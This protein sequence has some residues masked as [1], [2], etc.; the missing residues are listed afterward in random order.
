MESTASLIIA[1]SEHHS[2]LYYS[3]KFLAPDAFIFIQADGKKTLI[4]SDLEVD[5]ARAQARVDEVLS[6][7]AYEERLRREGTKDTGVIAVTD[8]VLREKG[9]KHLVV[10]GDFG[11]RHADALRARGYEISTRP[12][13]F[14]EER[15][16]KSAEEVE[17][18]S[19]TQRAVEAA[20]EKAVT[21]LREATV[22]KGELHGPGGALT[23]EELKKTIHLKLME[24]DCVGQHTIVAGGVQG[25][26]PHNEGSGPLYANQ[27][28]VMDVFPRSSTSRYYADMTRTVVKG[29]AP[30]ALRRLYDT[31][32]EAQE[33]AIGE[34]R[35]GI[36]GRTIHEGILQ[37]FERA[38][39]ATGV[40]NGRMQGFFHGT[41][42]GLGLDIHEPPRISKSGWILK[43]GEVV[44]V[45]PG[46]YY[47]DIGAVRIEDMV[48]VTP[49]GCENLT[50]FPKILEV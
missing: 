42:H 25:C 29:R 17:A 45:E 27:S 40:K 2:D 20:V 41:G 35:E 18:I 13:P 11:L 37:R 22:R 39:Y 23:S 19:N 50:R 12:D 10:P 15:M 34:V 24:L 8:A 16:V 21:L 26:D 38:G 33:A 49:T 7:S 47:P 32:L 43:A 36:D 4:M 1:S 48:W 5:R 30:E 3:T 46:L 28:I 14:F 6:F 44:T 9:F 31:V